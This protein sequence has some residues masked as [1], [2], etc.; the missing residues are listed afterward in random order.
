M[1]KTHF[2]PFVSLLFIITLFY[3]SLTFANYDGAQV[4]PQITATASGGASFSIGGGE[5][6]GTVGDFAVSTDSANATD[7]SKD[8]LGI[9]ANET[10]SP[11][12]LPVAYTIGVFLLIGCGV[13]SWWY[14]KV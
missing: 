3:P 10:S 5:T 1:K 11:L 6:S 9:S 12:F 2:L 7:D 4:E 13:F 14:F 8:I